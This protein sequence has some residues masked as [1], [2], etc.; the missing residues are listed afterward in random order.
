MLEWNLTP[1]RFRR[2]GF[3][4]LYFRWARLA[5][6]TSGIMVNF[7]SKTGSKPLP[8]FGVKRTLFNFGSQL[9]FQIVMLSRFNSTFSVGYAM[10]IEKKQPL[11]KEFMISLKIL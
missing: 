1:I 9:D 10:A 5:L 4:S 7:D 2:I 11:S 8:Q 6:F 3:T